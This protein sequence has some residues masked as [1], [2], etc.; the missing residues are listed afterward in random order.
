[1]D[2]FQPKEIGPSILRPDGTVFVTGS[3]GNSSIFDSF[4]GSLPIA[5]KLQIGNYR[6]LKD[7]GIPVPPSFA[8]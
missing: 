1:M 4:T 2:L 6:T 7:F 8:H 3:N 5:N